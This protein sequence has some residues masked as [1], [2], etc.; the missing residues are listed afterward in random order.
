MSERARIFDLR[1][2]LARNQD[3]W[4][5][6]DFGLHP[7]RLHKGRTKYHG[8]LMNQWPGDNRATAEEAL[9]KELVGNVGGVSNQQRD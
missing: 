4:I 9:L 3:S 5:Y 2:N 8:A 1:D 7:V 6:G